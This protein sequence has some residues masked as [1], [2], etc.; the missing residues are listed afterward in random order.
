[1]KGNFFSFPNCLD[2]KLTMNQHPSPLQVPL[3][4]QIS[5]E[6]KPIMFDVDVSQSDRDSCSFRTKSDSTRSRQVSPGSIAGKEFK[7]SEELTRIRLSRSV[8][9]CSEPFSY[10]IEGLNR[11]DEPSG[12]ERLYEIP[13]MLDFFR[14][15]L[16][17]E[18]PDSNNFRFIEEPIGDLGCD[19][20]YRL[21]KSENVEGSNVPP[22]ADGVEEAGTAAPLGGQ[23]IGGGVIP[24]ALSVATIVKTSAEGVSVAHSPS[25]YD[26]S[27]SMPWSYYSTDSF[28]PL[29]PWDVRYHRVH[30]CSPNVDKT[31][32]SEWAVFG[33][34]QVVPPEQPKDGSCPFKTSGQLSL[35]D[36]V[37]FVLLESV[38][39][40]PLLMHYHG[41][42]AAIMRYWRPRHQDSL[43]E[44]LE[45]LGPLGH[46]TKL[47]TDFVPRAFGGS[48]I[49]LMEHDVGGI[50]MLE[51]SLIRAPLFH[52]KPRFSDF[53]L[54]R[55]RGGCVLRPIRH[56]YCMGQAEPL[57][58]VDVPVVPRLHLTLS[59]RV[60]LEC[61]RF[62]LRAKQQP[63][64]DF[65]LRMFLGERK[66][67]LNRY[68]ADAV[69]EINQKPTAS[70]LAGII[71]PEEACVIN[72]MKEGLR[73][74]AERGID[75]ISA[76]S[77][78]R[79]RNYVRD[80]E[81]FER[82][83][84][85]AS[86]TPRVSHF[87]VQLENEMRCSPWNLSNDYWDVMTSKRGALFQFSPLGDPSGGLGEGISYRK[88]LRSE[89]ISAAAA[90]VN[91]SG[92]PLSST[93]SSIE[94]IRSKSKKQ[95][96]DQL[97]KLNVPDRVW[98]TMSRWQ[99]MRQLALL[100][101]IEDDSEE[102]LAPWK[103]KALHAEKINE[104]W[105]KQARALSGTT[106]S[107]P[108]LPVIT[109]ASGT[110]TP[111]P[112]AAEEESME[113]EL[114]AMMLKD[115]GQ[116]NDNMEESQDEGKIKITRLQIVTTGRGK[117][118]GSPWS[119]VTYVYG[120]RNIGLYRKW[121]ELEEDLTSQQG[122]TGAATAASPAPSPGD[123]IPSASYWQSK[124]EMSLKVHR[125]FQRIIRQ[126]AEA[127]RHIPD[128][129]RCGACY[130]FGHDQSFEGCPMLV[131]DLEVASSANN[132]T[133]N[134]K[135]KNLEQSPIYE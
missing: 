7:L 102:R 121:K 132:G 107:N 6:I 3:G 114:E 80:I 54:V 28:R 16:R 36:D 47:E 48:T 46:L 101:G 118:T 32:V 19:S 66:S 115:L 82:S 86:R 131:R 126:A 103:R 98:K 58:R 123:G 78:M 69:R 26:L 112:A 90:L 2:S 15:E 85:S 42:S 106:Y 51:S 52:H 91:I 1:M 18:D 56:V 89:A 53:L 61:R 81:V 88:I 113:E 105:A 5:E 41:M 20:V 43:S 97:V 96:I 111:V 30:I 11:W 73:R 119:K 129:K 45:A 75:R 122:P 4:L 35:I 29:S 70:L 62:W 100:L 31:G 64:M 67:L 17:V 23:P 127:G 109:A 10:L 76:I 108:P 72:A 110:S 44:P 74:L 94:E 128:C 87:C 134:K 33:A 25:A 49:K 71:S 21:K 133:S 8:A 130:L 9:S 125:R 12:R 50:T 22:E 116:D 34:K 14:E 99:M 57:Y 37:S 60:M 79:I 95:L 38:E 65:V 83:M 104:A 117:S 13:C 68:L 24:A 59:A 77:P 84:P 55:C 124:V 92:V 63:N 27:G 40:Y 120:H 93:T 135:R 39:Q